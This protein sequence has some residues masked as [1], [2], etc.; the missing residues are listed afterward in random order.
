[1]HLNKME[2]VTFKVQ[3]NASPDKV[4][5]ALW[6]DVNYR[7]W[8]S[9]FIEGSY[10]ESDW[11]E[12]SEIRFLSPKNSGMKA[13]ILRNRMNEEMVFEHQQEII[14]GAL[15]DIPWKGAQEAY[16]LK[17]EDGKSVLICSL[18][19]SAAFKEYFN[20]V[21]PVALQRVREIAERQ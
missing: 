19:V 8:T 3:I 9:V 2:K 20:S 16:L 12:G 10:A 15:R 21:F 17:E 18:D 11:R 1:M 7:E 5:S 14:N 4:W 13:V 6:Q